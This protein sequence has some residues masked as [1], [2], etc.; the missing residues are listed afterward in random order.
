MKPNE[1]HGELS[2]LSRERIVDAA[3]RAWG[4]THFS[5]TSLNLVARE[6]SVTKPAVYR[7]FKGKEELLE[8]LRLDYA[9]RLDCELVAPL[10]EGEPDFL[11]DVPGAA[12]LERAAAA[13]VEAV[14][15][16]FERNPFHYAFFVRYLL[17]HPFERRPEFRDTVRRH[18]ELLLRHLSSPLVMRYTS[19]T[20]AFWTTE[21]YRRDA[22]TGRPV[23]GTAFEPAESMQDRTGRERTIQ[24]I[25]QRLVQGFLPQDHH[26]VDLELVERIAWLT[27]EEMPLPDRVFSAIEDV[28][29]EQGYAAA[30][31]E[32]IAERVG[33]TKSSLY[34]YFR[35]RDEMLMQVVLRDQQHFASLARIRLQQIE[36]P[37]QQLYAFF[38]MIASYAVQHPV[39][40]IVE[41]W[42]REND[43][44]VE[45]PREHVEQ[46]QAIFE[47]L[48]DMVMTGRLA[49]DPGEAFSVIG[50]IRFLIMQELSLLKK[51]IGRDDCVSLVRTLFTLFSRG[52]VGTE[53]LEGAEV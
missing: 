35:N 31:V 15:T 37:E 3:F 52:L 22:S 44:S 10:E 29:Q 47:F 11:Q 20:A 48:T 19:S 40:M 50:F 26:P 28:V 42:I 53:V 32:R 17:G 18:D 36:H 51:P 41:N 14:Y 21:H 24:T 5:N 45:L 8:A 9:D 38:L 25:T 39:F 27:P 12:S 4:R 13:Y 23:I 43:V 30:T 6:L 2:R 34:H 1:Q 33:I 16:F 7:Y 46:M 49:A